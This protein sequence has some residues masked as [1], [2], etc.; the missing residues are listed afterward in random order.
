MQ[1]CVWCYL[2]LFTIASVS[3]TAVAA[4]RPAHWWFMTHNCPVKHALL[5][6]FPLTTWSSCTSDHFIVFLKHLRSVSF[7]NHPFFWLILEVSIEQQISAYCCWRFRFKLDYI[8]C[9]VPNVISKDFRGLM[10]LLQNSNV[11]MVKF[12]FWDRT[13][14]DKT[15]VWCLWCVLWTTP[16][17]IWKTETP[18][19]VGLG[20][21]PNKLWCLFDA[22]QGSD[23][24]V[25]T[26]SNKPH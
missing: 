2:G 6:C 16:V 1:H 14:K 21:L 10:E 5:E 8:Y 18:E 20:S 22:H 7:E 17:F 12:S 4:H 24:S 9:V 19:M 15:H 13:A 11:L 25:H 3:S 23:G 26:Y